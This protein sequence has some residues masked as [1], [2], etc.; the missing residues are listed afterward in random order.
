MAGY[1][2]DAGDALMTAQNANKVANGMM[3]S[4][5]DRDNDASSNKH[6]AALH[7]RGWWDRVGTNSCINKRSN[8][9]WWMVEFPLINDVQ[10]SHMLVK[11]N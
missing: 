6:V 9:G 1:S 7:G 8:V 4:T 11:L 5:P 10:T 2:E 3:F